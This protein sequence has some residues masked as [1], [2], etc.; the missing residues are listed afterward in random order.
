MRLLITAILLIALVVAAVA[1][2]GDVGPGGEEG[3]TGPQGPAGPPG[4]AGPTGLAG[5]P[6]PQGPA[7][8]PG[9]QVEAVPMD[10]DEDALMGFFD[11]F[12]AGFAEGL[13][14][15]VPEPAPAKYEVEEYTRWF[16]KQAIEK[17]KAEGLEATIAHYNTAG[18]R[19]RA[20]VHAH[21][22][23]RQYDD[24]S[25]GQPEPGRWA[26]FRG[27]RAEQLPCR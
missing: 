7:G 6:G 12:G 19:R 5:S 26:C 14:E 13:G 17:Y 24:C 2:Q 4:P 1:C 16:V 27:R 15:A 8:P 23:S 18:E 11:L 9:P 20:V 3:R 21:H 22:R 10:I 25:R